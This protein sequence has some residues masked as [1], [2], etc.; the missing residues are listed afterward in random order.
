MKI[1]RALKVFDYQ[2]DRKM[3]N[4]L[5]VVITI[6]ALKFNAFFLSG[7]STLKALLLLTQNLSLSNDCFEYQIPKR[8]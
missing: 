4:S 1:L 2:K 3:R 8:N 5:M 6:I 7:L